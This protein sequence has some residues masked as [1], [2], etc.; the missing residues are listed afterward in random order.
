[1]PV[2]IGG[3]SSDIHLSKMGASRSER[4]RRMNSTSRPKIQ[5]SG[6]KIQYSIRH[7]MRIYSYCIQCDV[8]MGFVQIGEARRQLVNIHEKNHTCLKLNIYMHRKSKGRD[9]LMHEYIHFYLLKCIHTYIHKLEG[10]GHTYI[11][12]YIRTYI[13]T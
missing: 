13:L 11:H 12:T 10:L 1:M 8:S 7:F 2:T 9:P 3:S 6:W 4:G 5:I